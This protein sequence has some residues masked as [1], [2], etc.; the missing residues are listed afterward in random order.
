MSGLIYGRRLKLGPKA[1][2]GGIFSGDSELGRKRAHAHRLLLSIICG[3]TLGGIF[4]F[5]LKMCLLVAAGHHLTNDQR[6]VLPPDVQPPT[7]RPD[8]QHPGPTCRPPRTCSVSACG[9]PL[10]TAWLRPAV[11]FLRIFL[12]ILHN[13]ST[14]A[15][16]LRRIVTPYNNNVIWLNSQLYGCKGPHNEWP[17]QSFIS[18]PAEQ[19]EEALQVQFPTLAPHPR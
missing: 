8:V 2:H 18:K 16:G 9:R 11:L 13:Y 14:F 1:E 5:S 17:G 6:S 19:S 3:V 10:G 15:L 4:F 12:H 7:C